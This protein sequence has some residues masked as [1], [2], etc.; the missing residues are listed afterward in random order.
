MAIPGTRAGLAGNSRASQA[1]TRSKPGSHTH[2][3]HCDAVPHPHRHRLRPAHHGSGCGPRLG[4]VTVT[5]P[6]ATRM[7][8][9]TRHATTSPSPRPTQAHCCAPRAALPP[10]GPPRA[11][12]V[13]PREGQGR[14]LLCGPG[15]RHDSDSAQAQEP[16]RA[17]HTE[18]GP[19]GP[20]QPKQHPRIQ[21]GKACT[22]LR[23]VTRI[24][25]GPG[26]DGVTRAACQARPDQH[27]AAACTGAE[28][29]S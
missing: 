12:A 24:G 1:P 25:P 6:R 14:T 7:A 11:T 29:A 22:R 9:P 19:A 21:P 23:C 26:A 27:P 3:Q 4:P 2:T 16:A 8:M 17:T 28:H 18:I 13:A 5:V 15:T 10:P 20:A